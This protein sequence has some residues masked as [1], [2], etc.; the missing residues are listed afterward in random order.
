MSYCKDD[1]GGWQAV[2]RWGDAGGGDWELLTK[3]GICGI[4]LEQ[5]A[6]CS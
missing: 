3:R 6:I 5:K 1:A 2:C 4:C